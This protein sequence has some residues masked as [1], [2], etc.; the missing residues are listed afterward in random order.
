[1]DPLHSTSELATGFDL[2]LLASHLQFNPHVDSSQLAPEQ[3]NDQKKSDAETHKDNG[4]V[5]QTLMQQI[6]PETSLNISPRVSKR[7]DPVVQGDLNSSSLKNMVKSVADVDIN[8]TFGQSQ[9]EHLNTMNKTNVRLSSKQKHASDGSFLSSQE[10]NSKKLKKMHPTIHYKGHAFTFKNPAVHW[11]F[12]DCSYRRSCSCKAT[13]RQCRD[14]KIEFSG[15]DHSR[16]CIV[17]I[18]KKTQDVD[19]HETRDVSEE[20]KCMVDMKCGE[21]TMSRSPKEIAREVSQAMTNKYVTWTGMT[22]NQME[23]RVYNTR[24]KLRGED[25]FRT[26][27]SSLF[28]LTTDGGSPFLQFNISQAANDC[29]GE[30]QRIVGFGHPKLMKKMRGSKHIFCDATFKCAP[31]PFKQVLIIVVYN[32]EAEIYHPTMWILMTGQTTE[33][34][35]TAFQHAK[36]TVDSQTSMTPVS[37]TTDFEQ[38]MMKALKVVFGDKFDRNGCRFHSK[39]AWSKKMK[40]DL[41]IPK[42]QIRYAMN[43]KVMDILA[44][45]PKKELISK[46]VPFVCQMIENKFPNMTNNEKGAWKKFWAYFI[47][48]WIEKPNYLDAWHL[49]DKDGH[50]KDIVAR[51]NNA[52]ERFNRNMG[53]DLPTHPSLLPFVEMIKNESDNHVLRLDNIYNGNEQP[54]TYNDVYIPKLPLEYSAYIQYPGS[55]ELTGAYVEG[56]NGKYTPTSWKND[57]APIYGKTNVDNNAKDRHLIYRERVEN[58]TQW[59]IGVQGARCSL[60]SSQKVSSPKHYHQKPL[61]RSGR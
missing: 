3:I 60:F 33:E 29:S 17:K 59:V 18:T 23:R 24:Q 15:V 48:T 30:L 56:C 43:W 5:N 11:D 51:T 58:C 35:I 12:Y 4:V 13:L 1:M 31:R 9:T 44:V 37:I 7:G 26:I 19:D 57:N 54:P 45:V 32:E 20:V 61:Y 6:R 53:E 47:Q 52:L 39:Q 28:R 25:I 27:E 2:I 22:V 21:K 41:H 10:P 50:V 42:E 46:G 8:D 55:I 40:D 34:Y 38:A 14:N 16:E 36:M 49:L